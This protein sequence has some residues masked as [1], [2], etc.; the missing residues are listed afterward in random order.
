MQTEMQVI[1]PRTATVNGGGPN[2]SLDE[3]AGD[4][5]YPRYFLVEVPAFMQA[6]IRKVPPFTKFGPSPKSFRDKC[7]PP[8]DTIMWAIQTLESTLQG[9]GLA[10]V[11]LARLN[12]LGFSWVVE[13][14]IY[15]G[16]VHLFGTGGKGVTLELAV[17]SGYGELMERVQAG[18]VFTQNP[19]KPV[20]FPSH[21]TVIPSF[22]IAQ[23]DR[24]EQQLRANNPFVPIGPSPVPKYFPFED[25]Q[26]HERTLVRETVFTSMT[27]LAAGNT[28]EE[29]FVQG[30]GEI[31][32]RYAVSTTL[33]NQRR[34]PTIPLDEL[35]PTN[36]SA[37]RA[38]ERMG[39][40]VTVKDLSLGV[41]VPVAGLLLSYKDF[42]GGAFGFLNMNEFLV[43]AATSRDGAVERCLT[44][45]MQNGIDTRVRVSYNQLVVQK[46]QLLY[47]TFPHLEKHVPFRQFMNQL[48]SNRAVYPGE[49]LEFLKEEVGTPERWDY[50]AVDCADEVKALRNL[51]I[52]NNWAIYLRD[53]NCLGFP[54]LHLF[55][56]SLNAGFLGYRRYWH[57]RLENLKIKLQGDVTRITDANL[58]CLHDPDVILTLAYHGN[59]ANVLGIP[60]TTLANW[61]AWRFFGLLAKAVGEKDLANQYLGLFVGESL[62]G[63]IG[64]TARLGGKVRDNLQGENVAGKGEGVLA[65]ML[66]N[67][68]QPCTS[69]RFKAECKVPA[70]EPLEARLARNYPGYFQRVLPASG[71]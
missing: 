66:P 51:C 18:K 42:D 43:G 7:L 59:M 57:R 56:P 20:L 68:S 30:M 34:A 53:L 45:L 41:G 23:N 26:T 6:T 50:R 62:L 54:A 5:V 38:L 13:V 33:I 55:V 44:E 71:D 32:E 65:S 1:A 16:G 39:A 17:A 21:E 14:G 10:H 52:C 22:I 46:I 64:V 37:I 27:G 25:I 48:Y 29:A 35:T 28:Y 63:D 40:R 11:H 69:C 67:C 36:R 15:A 19:Q 2:R 61:S 3:Q 60:T 8:N 31:F 58:E 4:V 24:F 47:R 70:L 9:T 12:P 49:D